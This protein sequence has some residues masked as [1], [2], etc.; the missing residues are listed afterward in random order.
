LAALLV[1]YVCVY[2]RGDDAED[3]GE[4]AADEDVKKSSTRERPRRSR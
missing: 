4:D 3:D 1:R 2:K